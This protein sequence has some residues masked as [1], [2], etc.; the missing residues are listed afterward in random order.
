MENTSRDGNWHSVV[1]DSASRLLASLIAS[2]TSGESPN[3]GC[4]NAI[5]AASECLKKH[6]NPRLDELVRVLQEAKSKLDWDDVHIIPGGFR[7][8]WHRL[9]LGLHLKE[10]FYDPPVTASCLIQFLRLAHRQIIQQALLSRALYEEV[11]AFSN[12][13]PPNNTWRYLEAIIS[14]QRGSDVESGLSIDDELQFVEC[15]G[16]IADAYERTLK[17]LSE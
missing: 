9:V 4:I 11:K 1:D 10:C 14:V 16:L 13:S 5:L 12:S 3:D 15:L 7:N 6:R 17:A 8:S 2:P